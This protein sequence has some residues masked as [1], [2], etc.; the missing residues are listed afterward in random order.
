MA[1]VNFPDSPSVNDE[2][3]AGDSI[4][5]WNGSAWILKQSATIPTLSDSN[6]NMN[7][8]ADPGN[9]SLAS[10][11]NH[12]HPSDTSKVSKDG[13]DTI[14]VSS[15][16]T[17]PLTIQNNGTGNSL[18]INDVASDTSPFII[19]A[20]GN[21]AIG[22]TVPST[23][24]DIVGGI[25]ASDGFSGTGSSAGI[26][27]GITMQY[28][29]E[30]S[31][32]GTAGNIMAYGNGVAAGKGLRMPFAGKLIAAT[33]SGVAING[34]VTVDAYV[35]AVTNT[36]YRLTATGTTT[37]IGVTQNWS[38]SPLSFSAGDTLAW[39]QTAVPTSATSYNVSYFI[40]FD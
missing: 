27:G 11:S 25:I 28:A 31:G 1:A 34:T 8:S 18:V 2:F 26:L 3:T 23:K 39:I 37:D 32:T 20:S 5:K 13:G 17:I 14:T 35:N 40:R 29:C 15:G 36:S 38:S 16:S 30:R 24:L 7:G 21:V 9:S 12:I 22:K 6:P 10:R 33:L 4:Y 19:D